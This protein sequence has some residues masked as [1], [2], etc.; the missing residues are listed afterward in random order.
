LFICAIVLYL[1]TSGF[2]AFRQMTRGKPRGIQVKILNPLIQEHS[3]AMLFINLN[4]IIKMRYHFF[5]LSLASIACWALIGNA[6]IFAATPDLG[7]WSAL[8]YYGGTANQTFG[9]VLSGEYSGVGET[10]YAAEVAYTL[11]QKNLIRRFFRPLFDTVQIAGNLA[12]RHDYAHS[13]NVKEG[14]LYL[15]WRW[16]KFPWRRYLS[17]SLAIGDGISYASHSP[18]ADQ[19]PGKPAN[20]FSRLLNYLMLEATFAMPSQPQLQLVVRLHH[21]CTAWG[22]YSKNANAGSTNAGLGLR[23]YF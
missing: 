19:E 14:S 20:N 12:Y 5:K 13:D 23:Y 8:I 10:I 16:T 22:T 21:R 15:I 9:Q 6:S 4:S 7:P 3:I 11:D 1:K 17:T 2:Q 18:L